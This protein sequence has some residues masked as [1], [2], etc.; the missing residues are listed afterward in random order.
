[1]KEKANT[2][3]SG[4]IWSGCAITS[5]GLK[6]PNN[7]DSFLLDG[8]LNEMGSYTDKKVMKRKRTN[9]EWQYAGVFDGMSG[10]ENGEKAS[11]IAAYEMQCAVQK[12]GKYTT[13]QTIE[14]KVRHG[15]LNANRRIVEERERCSILGTTATIIC[16]R[17]E[18][19][20]VFHLGDSR[21]Y[22]LRGERLYQITRDQTLATLRIEAGCYGA[23]SPEAD[24]DSHLLTEYVGADDTKVSLQPVESEWIS[25]RPGDKILLCS[26]GLYRGC[27][28]KVMK[29]I[30]FS[31][32]SPEELADKLTSRTLNEGG[33]DNITCVVLAVEKDKLQAGGYENGN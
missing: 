8:E 26:D 31:G 16:F 15:F 10:G 4:M 12:T 5:V 28:E 18:K 7:E 27:R 17:Q 21:A 25:V 13:E 6:R 22:L 30:L 33:E 9:A 2:T 3:G 11:Y 24:R 14:N 32:S 29:E 19:A 23:F 20:K 1:M